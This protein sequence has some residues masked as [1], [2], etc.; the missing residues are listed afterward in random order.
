MRVKNL[1]HPRLAI[2]HFEPRLGDTWCIYG[3]NNSGINEFLQLLTRDLADF[4]ADLLELPG[5]I[6]VISFSEQQKIFEDEIA[7]DDTD[8]LGNQTKY[9]GCL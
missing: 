3:S 6:P 8:F 7:K 5:A 9:H 1:Q 2:D 4:K